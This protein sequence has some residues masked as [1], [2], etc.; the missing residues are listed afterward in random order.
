MALIEETLFGTVD[1]VQ[2]AINRLKMFEPREG[3]FLAFSGGK[4]SQCIYHLAKMA[5]VKFEAHYSVTTVDPPELVRFI[6]KEYPDVIWDR[7]YGKDGKPMSMFRLISEHTQFQS[8]HF[9]K[10]LTFCGKHHYKHFD[11]C[12]TGINGIFHKLLHH[13]GGTLYNLTGRYLIGNRI[14][15]Q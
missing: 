8:Q 13:G 15:Q 3:Y 14:G 9:I 2:K 6:K 4:D 5:G 12:S 10:G 11:L 1:K 7:H